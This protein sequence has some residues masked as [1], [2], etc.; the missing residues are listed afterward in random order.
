MARAAFAR[1]RKHRSLLRGLDVGLTQE[2]IIY[3]RRVQSTSVRM[4]KNS[5]WQTRG[6]ILWG[7]QYNRSLQASNR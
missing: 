2:K 1:Y 4:Q 3:G 7:P 6:G 5:P